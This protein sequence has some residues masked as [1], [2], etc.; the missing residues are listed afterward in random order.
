MGAKAKISQSV[1]W[2]ARAIRATIFQKS[3][4]SFLWETIFNEPADSGIVTNANTTFTEKKEIRE[5][6]FF[7]LVST[8]NRTD[9]ILQVQEHLDNQKPVHTLGD[10]ETNF[11]IFREYAQKWLKQNDQPVSRIALACNLM[12]EVEN[13]DLGYQYLNNLLK[14]IKVPSAKEASDFRFQINRHRYS[15]VLKNLKIN[16]LTNWQCLHV[17]SKLLIEDLE[18]NLDDIFLVNLETDMNT[19]KNYG[20][21]IEQEDVL[22]IFD[23]L[24]T[25]TKETSEC[26]DA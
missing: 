6:V 1:N 9:L 20:K 23:E 13:R 14:D 24:I 25:F 3:E 4:P 10:F 16:R 2:D 21:I 12:F 18:K 8:F 26:G 7:Q 19:D 22:N 15:K 17:H 5:N 11:K